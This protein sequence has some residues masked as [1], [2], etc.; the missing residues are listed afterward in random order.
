M[1]LFNEE[2]PFVMTQV[3]HSEIFNQLI[4]DQDFFKKQIFQFVPQQIENKAFMKVE[5]LQS[6]ANELQKMTLNFLNKTQWMVNINL[7]ISRF[8]AGHSSLGQHAD[9]R[10]LIV[11]QIAG[12]KSWHFS[13]KNYYLLKE[14][15]LLYV[16]R[17]HKHLVSS[18]NDQVSI[19]VTFSFFKLEFSGGEYHPLWPLTYIYHRMKA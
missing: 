1:D 19:H 16:P 9:E 13:E 15:D 14:N 17:G 6:K 7:Y 11:Y 12:E 8:S 2:K 5:K 10:P 18:I 4:G 3:L